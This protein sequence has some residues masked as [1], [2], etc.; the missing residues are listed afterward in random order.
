MALIPPERVRF[1]DVLEHTTPHYK[2]RVWYQSAYARVEKMARYTVPG[3]QL[4]PA[5]QP[6]AADGHERE[7]F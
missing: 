7:F 3:D 2:A 4:P 1:C 6:L 5:G